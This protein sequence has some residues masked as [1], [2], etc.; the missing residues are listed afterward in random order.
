MRTLMHW[1]GNRPIRS[2]G[3]V[4]VVVTTAAG[5]IV[6]TAASSAS[7]ATFT[8]DQGSFNPSLTGTT[9]QVRG[10]ECDRDAN[11]QAT[12]TMTF[13]NKTTGVTIGTASLVASTQFAN[14][15][16]ATI[17]DSESLAPGS[18]KIQATYT[19]GGSTPVPRSTAERYT[20]TIDA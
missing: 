11:I 12:G 3:A 7:S 5:L 14:C 20:E 19:P 2:L 17:T 18:Y 10:L 4:V 16:E 1:F 6:G 8:F 13:V 15:G 9:F